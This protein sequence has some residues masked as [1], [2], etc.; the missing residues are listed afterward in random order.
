[1]PLSTSPNRLHGWLFLALALAG[2]YLTSLHS[3]LLFH[4]L[5]ELFSIVIAF[6]IFALGWTAHRYLKN[7]FLIFLSIAYFFVGLLDLLHTLSYKGMP[8]FPDY[9]Y[10]ANQVWIA[11]R[12]LESLSLLAAFLF[13]GERRKILPVLLF[14]LFSAIT[15][16]IVLSI[17]TWKVFPVCFVDGLGLTPFKK[18]AEYVI[19]A[20][21]AL[22]IILLLRN[23]GAF[24][25]KVHTQMLWSLACTIGAE[26]A[27]TFYIS[28]Y[29]FSNLVGHYFK[30]ASFWF[31]YRALLETGVREPLDLIFKELK[32]AERALAA[33]EE[34]L[35]LALRVVSHGLWDRR[36]DREEGFFSDQF[37]ATLGY[38]PGGFPPTRTAFMERMHPEDKPAFQEEVRSKLDQGLPFGIQFR[39]RAKDGGWRWIHSRGRAVETDPDGTPTRIVGTITDISE[40][41]HMEQLREDVE[42]IMRHDLKTPLGGILGLP[43]VLG[44][45]ENITD[46]QRRLLATIEESARRM[47][48][49]I[50]M[51]LDLFKMENG[52]YQPELEPFDLV[53]TLR[54]AVARARANPASSRVAFALERNGAPVREAD[55]CE[56]EGEE[57]LLQNMLDNLLANA[58]EAAPQGTTVSVRLTG[59]EPLLLAIHNY[60][61]VP[62][63]IR[64]RF[65]EKYATSGKKRGTGLGTYSARMVCR[66]MGWSISMHTGE[67]EGTT[68]TISIPEGCRA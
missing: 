20:V 26:L 36:L 14:A 43:Q 60:G 4:T 12:L 49:L 21:I 7:N 58:A 18:N 42:R 55:R 2:L 44:M 54:E 47:Q 48:R 16:L 33:S 45:D 41:K 61:A 22:D 11:T 56:V 68:L 27:F 67:T 35:E 46:E 9:D 40:R 28:N 10:Y 57:R 23:R 8:I 25:P 53:S 17:F 19:C 37:Y 24:T 29:G 6:G 63:E 65:F 13:L 15:A 38:K 1:M 31:I 39:M 5:V 51:S 32:E 50:D 62:Q 3:Y 30:L 59:G 66:A 34:R 52:T 64:E